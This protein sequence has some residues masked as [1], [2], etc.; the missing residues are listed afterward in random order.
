M[1]KTPSLSKGIASPQ[2]KWDPPR[3]NTRP[4][5]RCRVL[6]IKGLRDAGQGHQKKRV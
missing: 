3:G 5:D 6:P 4:E 2:T 1:G